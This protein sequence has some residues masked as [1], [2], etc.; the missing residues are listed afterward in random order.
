MI[1]R[2]LAATFTLM[3][4]ACNQNTAVG[5][6]REAQ[7]DP[8][9]TPAPIMGAQAALR[10]VT[11]AIIKPETMTDAD[12]SALGGM[13]GRCAV[14]LTEVAFPSFLYEPG[15]SGAI[16]LNG[17]LIVLPRTGQNRFEDGGLIVTLRPLEGEGNAGLPEMEMIVVPPEAEDELG[18]R[19][20]VQCMD[21]QGEAT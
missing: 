6:D 20:Y 1:I 9:P 12:V 15:A 13:D 18:Y 8:A 5:N 10:N 21:V 17:K 19:G 7:I 11:T 14:R 2:S 4:A 3:L 16:K